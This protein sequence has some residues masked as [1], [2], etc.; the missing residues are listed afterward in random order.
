MQQYL[1]ELTPY[2]FLLSYQERFSM[3][4]ADGA[5]AR[6]MCPRVEL[7]PAAQGRFCGQLQG[8][9]PSGRAPCRAA[10]ADC[11]EAPTEPAEVLHPTGT[12]RSL[13]P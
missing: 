10:T 4:H 8:A 11:A 12:S 6:S 3:W 5:T 9:E 13:E 1:K 7:S 2:E